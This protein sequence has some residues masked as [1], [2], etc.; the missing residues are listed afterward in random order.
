MANH[1]VRHVQQV[2]W[3]ANTV[4]GV[5]G[6]P[7]HEEW[8]YGLGMVSDKR[9]AGNVFVGTKLAIGVGREVNTS[10]GT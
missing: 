7:L 4:A 10:Q 2:V 6:D 5:G 3:K 9:K 1:D 8:P